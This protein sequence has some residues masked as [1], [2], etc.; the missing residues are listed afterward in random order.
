MK[1]QLKTKQA[2]R[3]VLANA[4][5]LKDDEVYKDVYLKPDLTFEQRKKDA[6]LRGELKQRKDRGGKKT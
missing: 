5:R 4:K 3:L 2:R 6:T 1:V